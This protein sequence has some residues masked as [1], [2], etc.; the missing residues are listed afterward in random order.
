MN[1]SQRIFLVGPMG[2]GKTTIGRMVA[3][4]MG[5]DFADSDH[6]IEERTGVDIN[7]I[8]DYEGEAGFR[9][10]EYEM[11]QQ[12]SQLDQHVIATGGGAILSDENRDLM[13]NTGFVVYLK[14]SIRQAIYRTRKDTKR[15]ILK[16]GN[17]HDIFTKLAEER[18]PLYES[19]ADC[20]VDT[21][22]YKTHKLRDMI[23]QHY[24]DSLLQKSK[25]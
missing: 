8:F 11:L 25:V 17:P 18:S 13:Q 19:I 24:Q 23:I 15:P 1:K 14:V 6:E 5:F 2:A 9:Q 20:M 3:K 4:D 12:L 10:R 7:T 22:R 21:D 16:N